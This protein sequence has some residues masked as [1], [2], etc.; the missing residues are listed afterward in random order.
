MILE[1]LK[2]ATRA[3]HMRLQAHPR[4]IQLSTPQLSL[5]E[6]TAFLATMAGFY[7]PMEQQLARFTHEWAQIGLDFEQRCKTSLL[8]HDLVALGYANDGMTEPPTCADLPTLD[9]FP[10]AL[11]CMYV[12]EGATLGGQLITR[13]MAAHF[14][15][16]A[17][18]GT[19]FYGSYGP[20][21]GSMWK[22]FCMQ[23]NAYAATCASDDAIIGMANDTF[24]AL[25]QWLAAADQ[26]V[27]RKH[28][29]LVA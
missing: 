29:M 23:V 18:S 12:L 15:L 10:Q 28:R 26:S 13:Q 20:A 3:A 6:Y 14:G 4:V 22:A 11:G 8:R 7:Q 19:A 17:E 24:D 21:V 1:Q 16:T 9:D 5:A 25:E 27:N 2:Q